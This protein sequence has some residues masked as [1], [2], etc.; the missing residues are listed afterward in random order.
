MLHWYTDVVA[1]KYATFSGRAG[2]QE[3]WMFFL[4]NIIVNFIINVVEGVIG[5]NGVISGLYSLAVLVPQIALGTRR[6]HDTGKSGWWQLVGLTGIGLLLLLVFF[7]QGSQAGDNKYG[8]NPS[9]V[10][11]A[12]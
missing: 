6:L 12:A 8:P 7:I 11:A 5:T 9:S 10:P 2:R 1:K 4:A 3:F